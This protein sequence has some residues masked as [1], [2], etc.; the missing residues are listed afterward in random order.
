MTTYILDTSVLVSNPNIINILKEEIIIPVVVLSELDKLKTGI[1]EAAKN[2]RTAIKILD[3]STFE[4]VKVDIAYYPNCRFGDPSYADNQIL[5]AAIHYSNKRNIKLLSNDINLRVKAKSVGI[6]AEEFYTEYKADTLYSGFKTI[7]NEDA[8]YDLLEKTWTDE[9]VDE[10]QQ[11]EC[12]LFL[13]K[14]K[15]GL[16]T[17]RKV[18]N[19]IR[20]L[21]K[22]NPFDLRSKNI[23]QACSFD[24]LMDRKIDLV[25]LIGRA[26]SGK[27]LC[28]LACAADLVINKKFYNKLVIYR[29]MQA[30]SAEIGFTP[31]SISEKLEPWFQPIYDNFDFLFSSKSNARAY[32][33]IL[34]SK[35]VVE[36]GAITYIR[37]RS[38]PNAIILIDEFQ[39][40]TK[41]EAKTLLTRAGEGTKIILTGDVEQ[42]DNNKLDLL[43]NGLTYVVEKFKDTEIAGHI[44][45]TK[46]ERSRLAAKAAEVL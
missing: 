9:C 25:T 10:L 12:V 16:A 20:I 33:D 21:N 23:E 13:N 4:N 3:K 45:F 37:G 15:D 32:L 26:G 46:C 43:N 11:N 18:G 42:I 6:L 24:L 35:G 17:G 22:H 31:G 2:S 44:T 19:K 36:F 28:A 5:E 1:G 27:T 29:P 41:E 30:V 8:G 7:V 14:D 39:N 38:I 40:L 34:M